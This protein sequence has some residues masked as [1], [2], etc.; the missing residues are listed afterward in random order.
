MS[1]KPSPKSANERSI[2]DTKRTRHQRNQCVGAARHDCRHCNPAIWFE[3]LT[4][5]A[6]KIGELVLRLLLGL[7]ILTAS[8]GDCRLLITLERS[9]RIG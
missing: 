6:A 3:L 4:Y 9:Q 1:T 7:Q 2:R 8:A 5:A